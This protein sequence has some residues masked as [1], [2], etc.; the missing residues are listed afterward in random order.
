MNRYDDFNDP[1]KIKSVT[2]Q[3]S[4]ARDVAEN[5]E[6]QEKQKTALV[7]RNQVQLD[8][9][10]EKDRIE[11]ERYEASERTLKERERVE[12]A[13]HHENRRL[14]LIAIGIAIISAIISIFK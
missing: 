13:R 10:R 5:S 2:A 4:S 3:M 8:A 12:L 1:V 6:Y 7:D 14:S 11:I 9:Q